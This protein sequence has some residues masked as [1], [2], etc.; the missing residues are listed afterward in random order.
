M[1]TW[2][3]RLPFG[4]GDH[5]LVFLKGVRVLLAYPEINAVDGACGCQKQEHQQAHSP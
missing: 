3:T 5:L 2:L 4:D 1:T